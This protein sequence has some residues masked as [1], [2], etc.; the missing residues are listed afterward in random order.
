VIERAFLETGEMTER[1]LNQHSWQ[2]KF[3]SDNY[4]LY[5]VSLIVQGFRGTK[6]S[7]L[8]TFSGNE[9]NF[10]GKRGLTVAAG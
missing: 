6:W 8:T 3:F 1:I 10:M 7:K 9:Q 4:F 2:R 5:Q